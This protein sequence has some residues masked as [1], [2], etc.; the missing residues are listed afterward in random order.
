MCKTELHDNRHC[1]SLLLSF[2]L[3]FPTAAVNGF[4]Y[5]PTMVE[6]T[7]VTSKQNSAETP[8]HFDPVQTTIHVF[9]INVI[10]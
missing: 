3:R 1:T 8:L 10:E 5:P 2:P 4:P 6:H 7:L 9:K